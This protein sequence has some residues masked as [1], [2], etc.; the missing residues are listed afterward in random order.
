MR[1]VLLRK[2]IVIYLLIFTVVLTTSTA[3]AWFVK[4]SAFILPT[5]ATSIANYFAGGTG[6]Q[7]NP[8]II[9]NKKHLYHLA[10]LQNIGDFKDKKYYF[11]IESDI[12]MEGMA[13]PPIGTE[14]CPFIGDLNG[15]YKVLS[16][17]FISNNK[18]E[19][20]TN[21]DLDN[22]DL[23]NKVGFFGKIDS[24]DDPYDEKTA[25]KAYNFYLENVN[26]GSVVNNSVVGIVAGHNNG[27]LSDI[28]V[29][30]NSFK[31][32]SGILSQS[33]YVLIGELGEN[34]YWH[35]MPSDGGNKILIDPNDPAD[36]FTNLTHINN[37]PQYRTVKASIP[38][39]AYMT[40][41]LSYN[42]SGPKGFYYI[43]TVT[44]DTITVNGKTVVTYT[45]KTY[46]SITALSEATEKGIPESFWYRY[47]GSNNSSRHIIPSAAP[48][49]QDLVTVPFEG[50]EIEIPQNGVWF[51]PKGSGTTGISFLITNKSDNAAMSIYEFSRD[52]QGKI[53]NWKEY[54]F[55]F[56]KKSFDNKNILYFTFNVKS[57]Y[58][59]VVSRSSNTQNTDAGFFYLILHG[60]GYQGNGTS[61][62]QFI[63][64]VR[65][66]NGQF[67]RVSD[68]SYKLNNT[69]LTYSGIASSTGY[70]YFNKT[71]YGSET[72]PYVYYISEIGNLLISDKAA[73]TQDS[74]PAP[75]VLDSIFPNWMA[76]YQNNP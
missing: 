7:N 76:N 8:F 70:L 23:G 64:Y 74:K 50:S 46:T 35:G 9:N 20:L 34:T 33:N 6:E 40:S 71:T 16:N 47:D 42:T 24:P 56:K 49:D 10:W 41:N 30:N 57:N 26:I 4:S 13:L 2:N 45:P 11:E 44:E 67:P 63:D 18:N 36:L 15:N 60:V 29:S 66:V 22:V 72:E 32:A 39:H 14:E 61:T 52:S 17:L 59:Y 12:D 53:I 19:L 27:Q 75:G 48:S 65:R 69:L 31:L 3:Y 51:K 21:F 38:E 43:D 1:L 62:T 54:S 25:G 73:G 5:T 37:V 58:E 68:D 28:G 55:I